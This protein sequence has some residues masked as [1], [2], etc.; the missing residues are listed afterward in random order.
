MRRYYGIDLADALYGARPIS[1]QRL[2][3][4][5]ERLPATSAYAIEEGLW[6][7]PELEIL[8]VIAESIGE[9]LRFLQA[10]GGSRNPRSP[11]SIQRPTPGAPFGTPA[12]EPRKVPLRASEIRNVIQSF[13]RA[14]G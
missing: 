7:T 1:A 4:L 11:I 2:R 8:A 13:D 6:W 9:V 14:G 3:A 5:V 10:L 12:P